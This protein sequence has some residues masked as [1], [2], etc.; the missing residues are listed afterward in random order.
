M[1]GEAMKPYLAI[2]TLAFLSLTACAPTGT[3][4]DPE[5]TT[6]SA[7]AVDPLPSWNEGATRT[8]ILSFVERTTTAGSPDF[9]PPAERIAVF[10]NDGTLWSEQ[11]LYFQLMFALDR[12]RAIA[13]DHPEWR[14]Q[15]PFRAI[16]EDDR[17]AL[18]GI[19]E[20][21]LVEIVMATHSGL[22]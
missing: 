13:D 17:E 7:A 1:K 8:A 12:V 18:A 9:V 2:S 5:S 15:E 14:D 16:L 10:D 11:P 4:T 21:E 6:S 20:H 22:T 3:E 19:G